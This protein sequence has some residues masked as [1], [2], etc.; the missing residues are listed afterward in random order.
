MGDG[1]RRDLGVACRVVAPELHRGDEQVCNHA[2][3]QCPGEPLHRRRV[4]ADC[5][6]NDQERSGTDHRSLCE[7]MPEQHRRLPQVTTLGLPEEEGCVASDHGTHRNG[8][9]GQDTQPVRVISEVQQ[10]RSTDQ[11]PHTG[12]RRAQSQED[13]ADRQPG[14][15]IN[16]ARVQQVNEA[17][18]LF[19]IPDQEHG[20]DEQERQ[21]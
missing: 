7:Q 16:F 2:H 5:R 14:G 15:S 6:T 21:R 10:I 12:N 17:L 8:R 1:M 9:P 3:D 4:G 19:Q 18:G 20:G 13:A 11:E